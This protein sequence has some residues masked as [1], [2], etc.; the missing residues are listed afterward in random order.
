MPQEAAS[1]LNKIENQE[2]VQIGNRQFVKGIFEKTRVIFTVAGVGKVSAAATATLLHSQFGVKEI[3]FTGVAGGGGKTVI[4]DIVVGS[5]Y[6]QHDLDLRPVFP[7]FHILSLNTQLVHAN[8]DLVFRMTAAA[9]RF[10]KQGI[11]FPSLGIFNPKVHTGV[12]VS[13]DQFIGNSDHH[14]KIA[15]STKELLADGFH[16]IEMEGA[17]V[18]QVCKELGVPFVVVRSISDKADHNA[19]VK[20]EDFLSQVAG[21]Y[22][23]GILTEYLQVKPEIGDQKDPL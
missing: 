23:L 6:L 16:A 18:A 5:S 13:G 3:V 4:G 20:F 14:K 2:V 1:I 11:S 7:Q 17:A 10:F 9:N 22:S 19:A 12:I 21:Q 8:A 15:D